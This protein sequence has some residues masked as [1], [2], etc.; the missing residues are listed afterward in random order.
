MGYWDYYKG[1]LG[2]IIGIQ[3]KGSTGLYFLLF[4]VQG[5]FKAFWLLLVGLRVLLGF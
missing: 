5:G 4:R 1:P 2:T 3:D